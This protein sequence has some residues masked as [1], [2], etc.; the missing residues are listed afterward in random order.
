MEYKDCLSKLK[1]LLS[2]DFNCTPGDFDRGAEENVV[3]LSAVIEGRRV[4][5]ET[6][7][8]FNMVTLGTNCVVSAD[9]RLHDFLKEFV[10]GKTG[11]WLFEQHNTSVIEKELNRYGYT[12]YHS[13][14]LYLPARQVL[15]TKNY[16]VKWFYGYEEIE[17][18][19]GDKRFP[20]ALCEK[21][22]PSRPDTIAVCA[23]DENGDIMGMA[24]CSEDAPGWQQIGIDVLPEYREKGVGTYLV[25]LLKNKIEEKGDIPFYG[26]GISNFRSMNIAIN[27]GFKPTWVEIHAV[28]M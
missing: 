27:T 28:K 25:T 21:Y 5:G 17:Q 15:P 4:Y 3:T 12:L 8:F 7:E 13:H 6:A 24:G 18:F 14:H 11:Y 10:K 26:T 2:K 23:Y 9:E 19:Y 20:N 16:P 22:T 1:I